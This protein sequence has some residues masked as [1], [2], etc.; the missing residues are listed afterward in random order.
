MRG[1]VC[2][3]KGNSQDS[4]PVGDGNLEKNYDRGLSKKTRGAK[5]RVFFTSNIV[6]FPL[7][8][9]PH[10]MVKGLLSMCKQASVCSSVKWGGGMHGTGASTGRSRPSDFSGSKRSNKADSRL[11]IS[12]ARLCVCVSDTMEASRTHTSALTVLTSHQKDLS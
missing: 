10:T 5:R 7:P 11:T 1:N 6:V 12:V 9:G 4:F 3:N 2:S 8:G